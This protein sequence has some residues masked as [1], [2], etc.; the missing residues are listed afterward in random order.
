MTM[1]IG[2][3]TQRTFLERFVMDTSRH[4]AF[5]FS[6][7]E[8][9]GKRTVAR[10]F[11]QMLSQGVVA[12]WSVTLPVNAD[13]TVITPPVEE[14]KVG[15][16]KKL[17]VRDISVENITA[18]RG[19]FALAADSK[20]KVLI[21]DDAHRMTT[22]A[23]N[24]LLK[25]LEEPSR[26]GV[27]I[28]V[29]HQ[30]GQL[31][32]TIVSRC[33]RVQFT[34]VETDVMVAAGVTIQTAQDAQGRPGFVH[35]LTEDA[36]FAACVDAARTALQTLAK[37]PIHERMAMAADLAKKDDEYITTFFVVWAHRIYAAAHATG[38]ATLLVMADRVDTFL[39]MFHATNANKQLAI[40]DLLLRINQRS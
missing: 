12:A 39:R 10:A 27:M 28:L 18:A 25:T 5:M 8:H 32:D 24:A 37:Q 35:R 14:K 19:R 6:G 1:I 17:V 9:V 29:T 15:G 34:T 11:A 23:Q 26:N 31:L 30:P 13:V 2:H 3:N 33:V 16:K 4:H 36:A 40:E 20:A 22:S 38:N 7:P 21:I